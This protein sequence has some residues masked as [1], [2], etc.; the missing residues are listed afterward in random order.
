MVLAQNRGT[1]EASGDGSERHV[2]IPKTKWCTFYD[3]AIRARTRIE[4]RSD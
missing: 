1:E 2:D 3:K 4:Y